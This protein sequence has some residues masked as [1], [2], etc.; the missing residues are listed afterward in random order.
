MG[1]CEGLRDYSKIRWHGRS[2]VPNRSER[3][4][5]LA[6]EK[7][8]RTAARRRRL[9]VGR[10]HWGQWLYT[11]RFMVDRLSPIDRSVKTAWPARKAVEQ[12]QDAAACESG[13]AIGDNGST[14]WA[15]W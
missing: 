4:D 14:L 1:A 15:Y 5:R 3:E 9:R 2:I 8:S 6:G 11:R 10:S 12:P 7:S 13:G